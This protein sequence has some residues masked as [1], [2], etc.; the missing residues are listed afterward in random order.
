MRASVVGRMTCTAVAWSIGG[1]GPSIAGGLPTRR[2]EERT[3][4]HPSTPRG[5]ALDA[6]LGAILS[7]MRARHLSSAEV[8]RQAGVPLATVQ[9][10]GHQRPTMAAALALAWALDITPSRI[11]PT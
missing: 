2:Q 8:A 10:I 6:L 5:D 7:E 4:T 3:M 1:G 11:R 9:A